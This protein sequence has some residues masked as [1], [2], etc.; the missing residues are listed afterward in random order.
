MLHACGIGED[1]ELA[2]INDHPV[3]NALGF[4]GHP[5]KCNVRE[6]RFRF[7]IAPANIG[8]VACEPLLY[9]PVFRRVRKICST[10]PSNSG[11][12]RAQFV[13]SLRMTRVPD[14]LIE[15]AVIVLEAPT[16]PVLPYLARL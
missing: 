14:A 2:P 15:E 9:E 11:E 8:M 16:R 6:S 1:I 3:G 4:L 5:F 13:D 7:G 10:S 12:R